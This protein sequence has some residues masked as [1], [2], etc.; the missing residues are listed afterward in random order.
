[1]VLLSPEDLGRGKR[2][3]GGLVSVRKHR[4]RQLRGAYREAQTRAV[5][6]SQRA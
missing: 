2:M 3:K 1:M 5:T 6:R 4:P